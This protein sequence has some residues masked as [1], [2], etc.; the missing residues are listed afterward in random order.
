MHDRPHPTQVLEEI[1]GAADAQRRPRMWPAQG[2]L[3]HLATAAAILL[4]VLASTSNTLVKGYVE[5]DRSGFT[6]DSRYIIELDFRSRARQWYDRA[7]YQKE[8]VN[9]L[10]L[11]I[12]RS[13]VT[14]KLMDVAALSAEARRLSGDE[15][16]DFG[17]VNYFTKDYWW[18]KG[19]SGLYRPLTSITYWW[20]FAPIRA[21]PAAK[22]QEMQDKDP[23]EYYRIHAATLQRFHWTNS[24]LHAAA[25]ILTYFLMLALCG[26]FWVA[27]LTGA[28]F[29]VHPITVESVANII[30]R[31]D[32][33]AAIAVFSA[34]LCYI[35]STKTNGVARIPWLA[36][37]MLIGLLGVFAKESALA[38]APVCVVYEV[39][40][41]YQ[42]QV[43][44][45]FARGRGTFEDLTVWLGDFIAACLRFM[46][47]G[48]VWLVPPVIA[49]FYVRHLVFEATTPPEEPFLDNPIRGHPRFGLDENPVVS[50]LEKRITALKVMANLLIKLVAPV[51]LSSDYSYNQVPVFDFGMRTVHDWWA[52]LATGIVLA[53]FGLA[54]WLWYR[55]RRA[56]SYCLFFFF[57]ASLPTANLVKVIGSIQAERFM[58]LPLFGFVGAAS[59]LAFWVGDEV[60][61]RWAD[62]ADRPP[63]LAYAPH[64]VLGLVIVISGVRTF[65]RN[66]VWRS[67]EALWEA[68]LRVSPNSFRSYQ[69]YAFALYENAQIDNHR[70]TEPLRAALRNRETARATANEA[71]KPEPERAA[72][73]QAFSAA[74]AEVARLYAELAPWREEFTRRVQKMIE[75]DERGLEIVDPLPPVMNSARLYLHLGMYYAEM[76]KILSGGLDPGTNP[77]Q[78]L[79]PEARAWY[80]KSV[81]IL[82]R[83]IPID[84]AF[85]DLNR[86]KEMTRWK[87]LNEIPDAGLAPVYQFLGEQQLRLGQLDDALES[88]RYVQRLDPINSTPYIQLGII[89]LNQNRLED[90]ISQLLQSVIIDPNR[91]DAW[92]ILAN[93]YAGLGQ[94]DAIVF[95]NGVRQ[96]NAGSPLVQQHVRTAYR[97]LVRTLIR[98]KQFD[99]ARSLRRQAVEVHQAPAG[100][101]DPLFEE[102]GVP[103]VP[104]P[105]DQVEKSL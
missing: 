47:R 93:V 28:L 38:F 34:L 69:S 35:R 83:A 95:G 46:F 45:L 105:P 79:S 1:E 58:Y 59:L 56:A 82:K 67:D 85:N 78:P 3:R 9:D 73:R 92:P 40:F 39:L 31:A 30:G 20:N 7:E 90:A 24:I 57:V 55:G 32:I 52:I 65:Y 18:P 29:S 77:Q 4:L 101:F 62:R 84:R 22:W 71:T 61:R 103:L 26:R 44:N 10:A 25:A 94:A 48:W 64:A 91:E 86:R 87:N 12:G 33:F 80:Q 15:L 13:V 51:R 49:V 76:G 5:M 54:F 68:A 88:Y 53:L 43:Q 8:L 23:Q 74:E 63:F 21:I 75:T 42:P 36:L 17:F 6:L 100:L 66:W 102:A 104:P 96:V 81:D 60:R 2:I 97:D 89:R 14:G 27:A 11:G 72:A 98:G 50:F 16:S 99:L 37:T 41:R 19:I 70:K